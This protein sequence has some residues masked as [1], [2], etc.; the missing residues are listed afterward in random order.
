MSLNFLFLGE[1]TGRAGIGCLKN[2]LAALKQKYEVDFT[3]ADGEGATGGFGLG[4]AHSV[5]LSKLGVDLITGGEK[6]YYKPDLVEF[7]PRCSFILRPANYP[8]A[9]PGKGIKS[10][11]VKG[12]KVAIVN[13]IGGS[14]FNKSSAQNPF[15]FMEYMLPKLQKENDLILVQFHSA[16]TAETAT[17]GHYLKGAVSA[18]IGVHSKVLTADSQ[19][20]DGKTAFI[21]D[22]G[23]CGSF[24]SVGG[25]E[26]GTE[27][28]KFLTALPER[29]HEAWEEAEIQGV[30]VSVKDDLSV[31]IETIKEKVSIKKPEEEAV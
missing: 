1:I 6:L 29:S 9:S 23:R 10:V 27:I 25:F 20:L 7:L 26:A 30:L 31:K 2:G 19:V 14:G 13:L 15:A 28:K 12:K 4:K 21:S 11:N 18:V 3:I 17:M 8:P 16:M 22:A 5:L 24:M